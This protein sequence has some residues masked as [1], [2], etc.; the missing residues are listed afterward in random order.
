MVIFSNILSL[1][2]SELRSEELLAELGGDYL[3][4]GNLENDE[5]S[6]YRRHLGDKIVLIKNPVSYTVKETEDGYDQWYVDF[7][8]KNHEIFL[9]CGVDDI[10]IFIE[11]FAL[12]NGQC[13]VEIL[14]QQEV[15]SLTE[16]DVALPVSIYSL[17]RE[18]MDQL[19]E[20]NPSLEMSDWFYS[21]NMMDDDE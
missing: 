12:E 1:S 20:A 10:T 3:L 14:Y 18:E 8:E 13:N 16:Y 21:A 5:G 9:N 7:V 15:K 6:K 4:E 2:G 17:T 19:I 11:V